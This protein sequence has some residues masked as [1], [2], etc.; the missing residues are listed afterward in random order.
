MWLVTIRLFR[1]MWWLHEN[2]RPLLVEPIDGRQDRLRV[3]HL[4][5]SAEQ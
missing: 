3:M 4:K 2:R 1:T 5:S